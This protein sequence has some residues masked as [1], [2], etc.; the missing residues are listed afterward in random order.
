[1]NEKGT[2]R[3]LCN[4]WMPRKDPTCTRTPGHGGSFTTAEN[5]AR[6]RRY[7]PGH[8]HPESPESRKKSNRKYRISSYGLTRLDSDG[9]GGS[10]R[11]G[12]GS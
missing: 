6:R 5:M 10:L 4:N 12:Q 11:S 2:A 8:P 3:A 9:T 7:R 1:V